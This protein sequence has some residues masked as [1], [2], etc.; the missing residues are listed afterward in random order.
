MLT[1]VGIAGTSGA[2]MSHGWVAALEA[3]GGFEIVANA[4]LGA[5][6]AVML[7]WRLPEIADV[8]MDV[9]ILDLAVNEARA[10]GRALHDPARTSEVFAWVRAWCAERGILPVVL[11][12]PHVT[13][14]QVGPVAGAVRDHWA[15]MARGAGV[16]FLD[17]YRMVRHAC[18][19][20]E[21]SWRHVMRDVNHLN[22]RGARM[23]G[24][25]LARGLSR[26]LAAARVT[27][28]APQPV[29]GYH[30]HR[31]RGPVEMR[32]ALLTERV[33]RLQVGDVIHAKTGPAEVAGVALNMNGTTGALAIAGTRTLVKRLDS[34]FAAEGKPLNLVCWSVLD[35]VPAAPEGLHL[36]VVPARP[37]A[38]QEDNDHSR[39]DDPPKGPAAVDLAGLILRDPTPAPR[40]LI[41][42]EGADPDIM[43]RL[44]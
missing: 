38:G 5:S 21:R 34:P 16:P 40:R 29:H 7:P 18:L 17:G 27:T 42:A 22:E 19:Y 25:V 4:S 23:L 36:G 44:D 35:P 2:L 30:A 1:R 14:A 6:H 10:A 20:T 28:G 15:Q 13:D 24:A 8:A 43:A 3:E 39:P 41:G 12:L 11:I 37:M 31:L 26:F 32:S 33:H 9:L